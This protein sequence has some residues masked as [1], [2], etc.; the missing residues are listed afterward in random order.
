[1]GYKL[2]KIIVGLTR[3]FVFVK[4]LVRSRVKKRETATIYFLR[5]KIDLIKA[6]NN[7]FSFKINMS[8]VI[9][10]DEVILNNPSINV[11]I[12]IYFIDIKWVYLVY[13]L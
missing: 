4:K 13:N 5:A 1:M 7:L 3:D 9:L 6:N 8:L 2:I 12:F 10:S 11:L